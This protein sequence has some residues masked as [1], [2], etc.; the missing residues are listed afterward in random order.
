MRHLLGVAVAVVAA[1]LGGL[2]LGE[3]ELGGATAFVAAVLF[4]LA[5][6]EAL[7]TVGRAAGVADAILAAALV[8]AAFAWS[9]W[10]FAG[11]DWGYV[12][13]VRWAATPVGALAA[14][15]WVRSSG[16]RAADSSPRP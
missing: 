13:N 2:I 9:S 16:R 6:G 3:Y 1:V 10:I 5:V 4:G 7:V 14:A 11:R 12:E 8:G 15:L